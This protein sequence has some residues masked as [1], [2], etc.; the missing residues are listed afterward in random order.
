MFV[1]RMSL[2]ASPDS[3][4]VLS[5]S[6]VKQLS[7]TDAVYPLVNPESQT[8]R[9]PS[10]TYLST[11]S[12]HDGTELH[13]SATAPPKIDESDCETVL[14][15]TFGGSGHLSSTFSMKFGLFFTGTVQPAVANALVTVHADP[16]IVLSPPLEVTPY[17]TGLFSEEELN[18]PPPKPDFILAARAL[19][20]ARGAFR[21]GP[22]FFENRT[23]SPARPPNSFLI[24]GVHK[25]GFEFTQKSGFDWLTFK[26][27][28]LALVEIRVVSEEN[29]EPLPGK[30]LFSRFFLHWSLSVI[31]CE[32]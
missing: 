14:E 2:W 8:L 5:V 20:D 23:V 30:L 16:Y 18:P 29:R 24:L 1:S 17:M 12:T 32:L 13:A 9:V 11:Q 26:A 27:R 25:P 22:F 15:T 7:D 10:V 4:V 6:P 21:I 28:K 19:T 31:F 3:E